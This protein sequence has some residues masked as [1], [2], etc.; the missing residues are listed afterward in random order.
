MDTGSKLVEEAG[1]TISEIVESVKHVTDIMGEISSASEEQSTRIEQV[2][3]AVSQMDEVT[4]QN[5]S[6]VEEASTAAQ[7]MAQQAQDLRDAVAFLNV[8]DRTPTT[9]RTIA[10]S[11]EMRSAT[12]VHTSRRAVLTR[13]DTTARITPDRN[14]LN[15]TGTGAGNWQEV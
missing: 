4:Q 1:S 7:A 9:S 5:A 8:G 10:V 13:A 11:S 14:T 15:A 6:L 12:N 2:S 3:R